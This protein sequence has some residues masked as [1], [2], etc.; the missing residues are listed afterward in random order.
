MATITINSVSS[1]FLP[2]CVAGMEIS[3]LVDTGAGVSLLSGDVL[4]KVGQ[5]SIIVEPVIHQKLVGVDGIPLKVP[6]ASTFPLTIAG[7]EFQHR[8][9]IADNIT[10]DAILGGFLRFSQMCS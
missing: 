4:D 7:L 9:I 2:V 10:A 8:L 5:R 6:G 3:C 1:Y